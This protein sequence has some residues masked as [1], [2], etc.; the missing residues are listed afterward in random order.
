MVLGRRRTLKAS[1][2]KWCWVVRRTLKA[3]PTKWCWVVRRTL[4]ASPTKWCWVNHRTLKASPT[5]WCWVVRR[6]LK[7]SP[8][9]WCWVIVGLRWSKVVSI[10][11]EF[12][13]SSCCHHYIIRPILHYESGPMF[14]PNSAFLLVQKLK[15][16]PQE[17]YTRSQGWTRKKKTFQSAPNTNQCLTLL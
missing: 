4:K 5:K 10:A 7:A 15:S 2:T 1:P 12:T 16:A 11:T 17:L 13:A 6:S 8:T 9:K 3:S 14:N